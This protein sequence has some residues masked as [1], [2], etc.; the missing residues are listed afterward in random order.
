MTALVFL[1]L[2]AVGVEYAV[3][4]RSQSASLTGTSPDHGASSSPSAAVSTSAAP[5]AS[6]ASPTATPTPT[7][8]ATAPA[9]TRTAAPTP[10]H[11]AS[12]TRSRSATPAPT[13]TPAPLALAPPTAT[14]E[15]TLTTFNVLGASHT[16]PGGSHHGW[17]PG[18]TR[19]KGAAALIARHHSDVVGFQELQ[20]PQLAVLRRRTNLEF[21]PGFSMGRLDTDN[22]LGWRRDEWTA[23]EKHVVRIPY[24]DGGRRSMPFVRLRNDRTGLQAWFANFHNPAET[25]RFH[26]Q[27]RF[28]DAATKIEATLA[29]HLIDSSDLPVFITG[30]MNERTPYFCALTSTAPMIAARGGTNNGRCLGGRPRA[31]DWIFGSQGVTFSHYVEDRSHLVDVTTDH[32]VVSTRVEITGDAQPTATP[33]SL[34]GTTTGG[35]GD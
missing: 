1:G 35:P 33:R 16:A 17:A 29:N 19:A 8:S 21:Y 12:P 18:P 6:T 11:A 32:P 28:R 4:S 25:S 20:G 3:H 13:P 27:Q 22:S 2:V 23:M 9:P 14:L 15:F 10:A 31:V 7:G 30:D 5:S 24:F 26:H 34:P